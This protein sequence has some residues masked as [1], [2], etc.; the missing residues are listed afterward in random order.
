MDPRPSDQPI[1]PAESE[2]DIPT[3]LE[4][5]DVRGRTTDK[6]FEEEQEVEREQGER[7]P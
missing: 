1:D 6:D 7:L 2:R 4:P 5:D 3:H